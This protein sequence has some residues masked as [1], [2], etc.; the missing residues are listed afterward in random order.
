MQSDN[1]IFIESQ[2]VRNI[3]VPIWVFDNESARIIWANDAALEIWAAKD[4]AELKRRDF[5]KDMSTAVKKRLN[6]YTEDFIASNSRFTEQWTLYPK[7]KPV[8]VNI[9]FSG[10]RLESDRIVTLCEGYLIDNIPPEV[11][12][13]SD[14]LLHTRLMISLHQ[15]EGNTLYLNPAARSAFISNENGLKD[16]FVNKM[17][18]DQ[19]IQEISQSSGTNIVT[20]VHTATGKSWHDIEARHCHDPV[21]GKLSILISATDVSNLKEAEKLAQ[22]VAMHDFLTKLPNRHALPTIFQKSMALAKEKNVQI[23]LMFIDLDEFKAINDTL[24]HCEGDKV[25]ITVAD[26]LSHLCGHND[27]VMR[28][29]GDEFLLI[30][31][32]SHFESFKKRA[33][34]VIHSIAKPIEYNNGHLSI[35]PSVGI[36][37]YPTHS[38]DIHMLMQYADLAMYEAKSAGKNQFFFFEEEIKQHFEYE[39]ELLSDLKQAILEN[40]LILHYQPRYST[41][42]RKII[43]LE[44][45]VR[46]NHPKHGLLYPD[47]FIPLCEQIGLI[48]ELG[49][50]VLKEAIQQITIW[51]EMQIDAFVSINV[52]IHQ[53]VKPHFIDT[54][55]KALEINVDLMNRLEIELTETALFKSDDKILNNINEIRDAGIKIA[56]DDFG[57]GYS[58]LSRLKAL[59]PDY[60]KIDRSLI[61]DL[62]INAQLAKIVIDICK[63]MGADIIAEGIETAE[64]AAWVSENGCDEMQG[65]F[66]NKALPEKEITPLLIN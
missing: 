22:T 60:I 23:A 21:T 17:D 15:I 4:L 42:T 35:T 9:H 2:I 37:L 63:L 41:K 32:E 38:D 50:W 29:G 64:A 28:L 18:Y 14:A 20:E 39:Y 57:M 48:D 13:G 19:L 53:L 40:Q 10:I 61:T 1:A 3:S 45:L 54:L 52:S 34:Q 5:Q 6:Q 58:N 62:P 16:R 26:R 8:H 47:S 27:S 49:I 51:R 30:I 56:V 24:G 46:W 36:S 12:R 11:A 43:A 31:E 25:L 55:K 7:G 65:F 59:S 66:F 44:G 33:S